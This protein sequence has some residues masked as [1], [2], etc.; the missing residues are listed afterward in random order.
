[1]A[2]FVK[3]TLIAAPPEEVFAFHESPKALESLIPPW[4]SMKVVESARSLAVGSRVVLQGQMLFVPLKWVAVHTAYNPPHEFE[5][6]QESGPFAKWVHK[7][8]FIPTGNNETLLRDEVEYQVPLGKLGELFGGW[9][10]R[11]KLER[12]F[13]YRHEVTKRLVESGDWRSD[14][15]ASD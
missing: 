9:F 4:E 1:M 8:Q 6:I 10:V 5:D 3:E 14:S 11:S 7:H 12:M 13:A 15:L 2:L